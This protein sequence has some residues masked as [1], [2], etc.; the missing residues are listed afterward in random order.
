MTKPL[1]RIKTLYLGSDAVFWAFCFHKTI[2]IPQEG[3]VETRYILLGPFPKILFILKDQSRCLDC[4]VRDIENTMLVSFDIKFIRFNP[5]HIRLALTH[6]CS[7]A[8]SGLG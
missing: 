2:E 5:K 7:C 3:S 6:R 8:V 4:F 1:S